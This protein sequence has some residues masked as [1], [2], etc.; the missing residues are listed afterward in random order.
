MCVNVLHPGA[1]NLQI[2]WN[3][4]HYTH[5]LV[6]PTFQMVMYIIKVKF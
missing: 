6:C 5:P 1:L 4:L 2:L 3:N